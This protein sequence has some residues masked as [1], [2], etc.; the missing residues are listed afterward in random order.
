MLGVHA[1]VAQDQRFER[2]THAGLG[3]RLLQGVPA[4]AAGRPAAGRAREQRRERRCGCSSGSA[5]RLA[6]SASVMKGAVQLQQAGL[7][8]ASR[9][10]KLPRAPRRTRSDI[11]SSSRS[12]SMGGLVTSAKRCRK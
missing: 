3:R 4:P 6:R 10:E 8:R 2:R 9:S 11:T 7:R 12:G 5:R 1:P